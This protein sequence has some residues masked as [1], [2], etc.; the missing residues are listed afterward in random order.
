MHI[1]TLDVDFL[2]GSKNQKVKIQKHVQVT[3]S[4]SHTDQMAILIRMGGSNI[5]QQVECVLTAWWKEVWIWC[6][7]DCFR[8]AAIWKNGAHEVEVC[9][10]QKKT[11]ADRWHHFSLTSKEIL[12]WQV[13]DSYLCSPESGRIQGRSG[14]DQGRY[15]LHKGFQDD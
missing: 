10:E 5:M 11:S 15:I 2:L 9:P 3:K 1:N 13:P 7:K 8:N 6:R 14:P 12:N 4:Y